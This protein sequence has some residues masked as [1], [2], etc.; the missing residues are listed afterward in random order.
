MPAGH[1]GLRSRHA[2]NGNKL[3]FT[4]IELLVVIAIIAILAAMLLPALATAKQKALKTQCVSN[5][6]QQTVAC[7]LYANDYS[8]VLPSAVTSA[9]FPLG[10][11]A[12]Y[13]NY[14][15]KQG[16]EYTGNLRLVNPYVG[17]SGTVATNS[18]GAE[19]VFKCPGDDGARRASWAYDRK[20]T[21]YDTF[22]S[23]YLYNSS[24]NDNDDAKG[25]YLKKL[26]AIRFPTR[27]ILVN[28][29]SFNL[30]L[31]NSSIF[32]YMYWHDKKR[33]GM[34]NLAFID[35]HVQY[36]QTTKDKPDFQHGN[37]WSFVWNE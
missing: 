8:D 7:V 27:V 32:Q 12:T 37:G 18:E 15:G 31:I 2:T 14:G 9:G 1:G 25:L 22:G 3:G 35:S 28:D 6:K 11:V 17:R 23:S 16:T 10:S 29:F 4:L 13:Y 26:G 34:G 19:R 20:P 5:L 21:V 24:A 30:Y 33:L 36:L